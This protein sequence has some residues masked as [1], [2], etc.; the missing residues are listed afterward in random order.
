MTRSTCGSLWYE[1][2]ENA[3]EDF[4][5]VVSRGETSSAR[6]EEE[7]NEDQ[8]QRSAKKTR[9]KRTR[10]RRRAVRC[11]C[12]RSRIQR[13]ENRRRRMEKEKERFIPAFFSSLETQKKILTLQVLKR[14]PVGLLHDDRFPPRWFDSALFLSLRS[15]ASFV[16]FFRGGRG[17]RALR[18]SSLE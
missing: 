4:W 18:L 10:Q 13:E 5:E 3:P 7:K 6:D 12:R 16:F 1:S 8:E 9:R 15:F 11:F 14:A 2:V 17:V